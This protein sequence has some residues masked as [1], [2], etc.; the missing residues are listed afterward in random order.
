MTCSAVFQ[1]LQYLQEQLPQIQQHSLTVAKLV[2]R[3]SWYAGVDTSDLEELIVAALLHDL[4]KTQIPLWILN[5]PGPLTTME[6]Q[7]MRKHPQYGVDMINHLD[8]SDTVRD[9]IQCH[10]ERWDGTGYLGIRGN[11]IPW[12]AC[13]IVVCDSWDAMTS[14]RPYQAQ[15]TIAEARRELLVMSGQQFDPEAVSLFVSMM[16]TELSLSIEE[17]LER[18]RERAQQLAWAYKKITHP[19][20][21]VESLCIDDLVIAVTRSNMVGV[22]QGHRN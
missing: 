12:G 11:N 7:L 16:S 17:R 9:Y 2:L 13:L 3:V 15:K 1:L 10:H 8:V 4:G 22:R 6:W 20:A 5:K 14:P 19:V 18:G 21:Y